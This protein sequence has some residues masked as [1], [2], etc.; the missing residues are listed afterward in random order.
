MAIRASIPSAYEAGKTLLLDASKPFSMAMPYLLSFGW[1]KE[2]VLVF[3][4]FQFYPA[5]ILAAFLG[6]VRVD[7]AAFAVADVG[8]AI[9]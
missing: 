4:D 3:Q 6:V 7:G 9:R 5:V 8:E 1:G 2:M